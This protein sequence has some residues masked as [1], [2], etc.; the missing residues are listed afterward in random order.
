MKG[1]ARVLPFC[2][3]LV[4]LTA[5]TP[6]AAQLPALASPAAPV[7]LPGDPS[8]NAGN[9][10]R[11]V[12]TTRVLDDLT[13]FRIDV[14][15][16]VYE[17]ELPPSG[18]RSAMEIRSAPDVVR[19]AF[20]QWVRDTILQE[21]GK[22]LPD[23]QLSLA[24]IDFD[25]GQDD[26]DADPYHPGVGIKAALDARF[27][28]QFFGLPS[29]A[30][31]SPRELARAFLYSGGIYSFAK[32]LKV[33]PGYDVRHRVTVPA[34]LELATRKEASLPLIEFHKDNL[35]GTASSSVALEFKVSVRQEFVPQNVLDGPLV[36][37]AFVVDEVTPFWKQS[38]PGLDGDYVGSLDL[39]IEV[40]SLN[41]SLF[42]TYPLPRQL[43]L[44]QV[45]AD[46]LRVAIREGYVDR[47][48][49][50]AFFEDLIR[51]SLEE[52]FGEDI[53]LTMDWPTL[54]HS[55]ALPVGG[56]MG[57]LV[58]PVVVHATAILPFESNKMF[59]SSSLGRL[60][61]MTFGMRGDFDLS[62]DGM[63]NSE[64]TVAYPEGVHINVDDSA[65]ITEKMDWGSREGFRVR[66]D[67]GTT[68]DVA[69]SGRS[70]FD[71]FV[72]LV[73]LLEALLLGLAC[74]GIASRI[75]QWRAR[76]GSPWVE[77]D[78]TDVTP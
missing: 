54:D 46:V 24:S 16:T 5:A 6:V 59:V 67:H 41:A 18:G 52:G 21:A 31:T 57:E 22:A 37:A 71:A 2:A 36:K 1:F 13:G 65:G 75:K 63:W 35:Q 66:L 8:P 74:W 3:I 23:A 68:T 45:S 33:P 14:D 72:F 30:K 44:Q 78:P 38:V 55:L 48:D 11:A 4:A 34:F 20:E 69:I 10:I 76:R 9:A 77:A 51:T 42:G 49:L 40:N 58:D 47:D 32:D 53:Q 19:A 50:T 15:L 61:G 17:V 26:L 28:P 27:T 7:P 73:G 25:Y 64:Y 70:D 56:A 62:N 12:Y 43:K 29:T 60:V 39:R